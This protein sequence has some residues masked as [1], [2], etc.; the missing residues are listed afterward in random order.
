MSDL[1]M[2]GLFF[3]VDFGLST[4][5]LTVYLLLLV[6]PYLFVRNYPSGVILYGGGAT[7]LLSEMLH[8]HALGSYMLGAGLALFLF[9]LMLDVINWHHFLPQ[10]TCLFLY[11]LVLVLTR[12]LVV[13]MLHG[14]WVLP[15]LVPLLL[16]YAVGVLL[17]AYR[18][19]RLGGRTGRSSGHDAV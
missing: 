12:L 4:S 14:Q 19:S 3:L 13:R 17:V 1:L 8:Q 7:V 6:P 9:H 5:G 18:F 2:F 16:T 10:V 11:F 15:A